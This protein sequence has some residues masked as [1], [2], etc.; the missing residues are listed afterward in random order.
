M[1]SRSDPGDV[2]IREALDQILHMN[3]Y[4]YR[5]KGNFINVYTV[6]ELQ[7]IEDACQG[8]QR[9]GSACTAGGAVS[10]A[11]RL[12]VTTAGG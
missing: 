9:D 5:E 11:S 1:A 8:H 2:T 10:F 6:K 7:Q 4:A 12:P 3:G